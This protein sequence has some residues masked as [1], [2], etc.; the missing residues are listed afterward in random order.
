MWQKLA[1]FVL[2]NKLILL[3]ALVVSTIVMGYFASK[4]KLSYEFSRAIPVDNIKY[5]ENANFKKI[6]GEDGNMLVIGV[7]T[8]T[9]FNAQHF[10]AYQK[11]G[12]EIKKVHCV[13][14][15]LSV[16]DAIMLVKDSLG[17]KFI[18]Q[19]IFALENNI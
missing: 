5:Q 19:K 9:F 11:M 1:K 17:E 14:N 8:N 4:V 15:V 2:K 12:A 18:P 16:P 10:T 3:I 6:F 7:Q 13:E